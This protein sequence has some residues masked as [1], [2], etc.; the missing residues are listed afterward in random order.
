MKKFQSFKIDEIKNTLYFNLSL[1][2]LKEK[3][4]I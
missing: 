4:K 2:L 3:N 1:D